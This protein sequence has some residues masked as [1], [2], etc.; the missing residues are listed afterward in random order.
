MITKEM[1]TAGYQSGIVKIVDSPNDDGAVCQ[2]GDNWF[3]F[4]GQTA[5]EY[6]AKEYKRFVPEKDIVNEIFDALDD[7]KDSGEEFDDEYLYYELYLNEHG[8]QSNPSATKAKEK[9]KINKHKIAISMEDDDI[10]RDSTTL[11][12][13]TKDGKKNRRNYC[14]LQRQARIR[15]NQNI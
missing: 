5:E 9:P 4:G 8:V 15:R 12:I 1:I 2:I 14:C 3:Y 11:I 13:T 6:T 10:E 7:F